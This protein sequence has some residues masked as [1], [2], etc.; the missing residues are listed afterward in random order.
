MFLYLLGPIHPGIALEDGF[1][2]LVKS[3]GNSSSELTKQIESKLSESVV[4][5]ALFNGNYIV[6]CPLFSVPVFQPLM[7]ETIIICRRYGCI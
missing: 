2:N 6:I 7:I 5:L 4:S 1:G 3:C